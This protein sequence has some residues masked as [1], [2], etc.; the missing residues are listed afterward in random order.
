[1]ERVEGGR[2]G[3]EGGREGGGREGGREGGEGRMTQGGRGKNDT[4]RAR[5]N[6]GRGVV[7]TDVSQQS[8]IGYLLLR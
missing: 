3:R 8:C 6:E 5:H 1:M 4:G 2:G 7:V